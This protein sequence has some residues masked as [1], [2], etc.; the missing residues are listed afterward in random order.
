M[1]RKRWML[2]GAGAAVVLVLLLLG[3]CGSAVEVETARVGRDT[4][5]VVVEE[6]GMTRVHDSFV[7]AAPVSGR[8]AR[9]QLV[10]GA[11]VKAG[12]VLARISSTPEDPRTQ[13]VT[14]AQVDAAAARRGQMA[15]ELDQ[16]E[17][18]AAQAEREAERRRD[19]AEAGALSRE[20]M[21]QAQLQATTSRRRV[22]SARAALAAATADVAAMRASL[23]GASPQAAGPSVSVTAPSDG[24]VLV[25]LEKSE[26]VV[27]AGTPLLELGDARGL[28]VVVDVLSSDAVSIAAGNPVEVAE[29]GGQR[30]LAGRVRLVEPA[31]FT[32][33][34]ALG[35]EEQRVNVIVDLLE[36]PP[37]LGSGYRVEARIVTWEGTNAL[38][39]P[40]SALF[41]RDGAWRLFV[42]EEGRARLREVQVGHRGVESAEVLGGVEEGEEV[43]MYPSDEVVEGVKVKGEG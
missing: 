6:E 4:L 15:A 7:V 30:P 13:T 19:L 42:V 28:E 36:A 10:E 24:R 31:A 22:E 38:T 18:Q 23:Q 26:R 35:V 3:T 43:V 25:V 27:A 2:I 8:L 5:R 33:I 14:R 12:E 11:P 1:T 32:E 20:E 41:Q 34:S 17:A 37:E 39:V 9:I 21:E 16:A 29:W 40:T